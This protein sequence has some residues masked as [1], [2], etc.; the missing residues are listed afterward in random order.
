MILLWY[1]GAPPTQFQKH[2]RDPGVATNSSITSHISLMCLYMGRPPL[3][4]LCKVYLSTDE[5]DMIARV[6]HSAQVYEQLIELLAVGSEFQ[7]LVNFEGNQLDQKVTL[8]SLRPTAIITCMQGLLQR[9]RHRAW[10]QAASYHPSQRGQPC[11]KHVIQYAHDL[12]YD[13]T[14]CKSR[15]SCHILIRLN[16]LMYDIAVHDRTDRGRRDIHA[17]VRQPTL[18]HT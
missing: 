5:G 7:L 12:I 16:G 10:R 18:T 3:T 13:T 8:V 2:G 9:R 14:S 11:S 6:V 15:C 17:R 1:S 4:A